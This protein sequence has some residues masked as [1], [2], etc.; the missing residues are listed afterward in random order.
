ME[1]LFLVWNT[2]VKISTQQRREGNYFLYT[3]LLLSF[4]FLVIGSQC[5]S[6]IGKHSLYILDVL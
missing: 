4:L 3:S 2:A 1:L 5:T 6:G